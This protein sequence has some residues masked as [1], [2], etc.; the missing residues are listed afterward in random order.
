MTRHLRLGAF[1]NG[2]GPQGGIWR[3]ASA[4]LDYLGSFQYYIDIARKLEEGKFD[5]LFMN[6]TVSSGSFDRELLEKNVA[7]SR[8]D[9]LTLLAAMAVSTSR[10]GLVGT[11]NT[12]YNEPFTLARRLESLDRLSGGRA[13]W[14]L[15][16]SLQGGQN[17]NRDD[18]V[19]HDV[20]YDRAEE[21]VDVL[22][23]LFDTWD[24]DARLGDKLSGRWLDADRVRE[25]NHRGKYFQVRGPLNAPRPVQ[26]WPVIAQAGSSGSGRKLG[27]RV[28][29]VIFTAATTIEE[30]KAFRAEMR[31]RAELD[32]GRNPD[33]LLV[34]PGVAV[35]VAPTRQEAEEKFDHVH[36]LQDPKP[37]LRSISQFVGLGI[38]LSDFPLDDVP[39]LPDVLPETNQHRS[40]QRLVADLIRRE[41]PTVRQLLRLLS[42]G[43]HRVLVGST[44]DVADNF[45]EWFR[46]GAADGFNIMTAQT[47]D[48]I[49]DFVDLV[50]P[51][52]QR[53]GLFKTAYTGATLRES[54]GLA[55][56][57]SRARAGTP[58]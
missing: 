29:E 34:M 25:L 11:A 51:E 14:N 38:D 41:R 47:P 1:L 5:I 33:S 37:A 18:H 43:G 36:D 6:D 31:R 26:G 39:V 50:V 12:T 17:F 48:A 46:A 4:D 58:Q 2:S 24:D 20:R 52:L 40:R 23:G 49:G 9:T 19:A 28:G 35:T 55:R 3:S 54:L 32:F 53:R 15:V 22:T 21:F 42:H 45:E 13:G 44:S 16:T 8:W 7:A 10:I 57:V 30:A 56:P 27:A